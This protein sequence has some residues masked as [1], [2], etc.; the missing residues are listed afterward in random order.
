MS[1]QSPVLLAALITGVVALMALFVQTAVNVQNNRAQRALDRE[2]FAYNRDV[3]E[4]RWEHE[5][6]VEEEARG[7]A[8][9]AAAQPVRVIIEAIAECVRPAYV[10][11][12]I[13]I[14]PWAYFNDKLRLRLERDDSAERLGN[15]YAQLWAL[16]DQSVF[17]QR[18]FAKKLAD[19]NFGDNYAAAGRD[20]FDTMVVWL[21]DVVYRS[22][23]ALESLG[24]PDQG[25]EIRE[26]HDRSLER[27]TTRIEPPVGGEGAAT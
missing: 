17:S 23:D 24:A 15:A 16:H 13:A 9:D 20:V 12:T 3:D 8:Y 14:E 18:F 4:R 7:R 6:Q 2:R 5:R 10:H 11:G 22:A 1:Q 27:S 21:S 25:K 26:R 19:P